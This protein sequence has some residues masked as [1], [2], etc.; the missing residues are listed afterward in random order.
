MSAGAGRG[1]RCLIPLELWLW[2]VVS[3]LMSVLGIE[4]KSS[5]RTVLALTHSAISPALKTYTYFLGIRS[6]CITP[7]G[8][9]LTV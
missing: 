5:G 7:T 1:Q 2:V 6:H 3:H 9:E 4:L 8:L